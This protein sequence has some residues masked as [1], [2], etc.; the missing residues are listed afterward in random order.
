[1]ISP[2]CVM[3]LSS[4]ADTSEL[5]GATKITTNSQIM[6]TIIYTLFCFL[7]TNLKVSNCYQQLHHSDKCK[8][9]NLP[10]ATEKQAYF[11]KCPGIEYFTA[12]IENE[13]FSMNCKVNKRK[14]PHFLI[15]E[16]PNFYLN[17]FTTVSISVIEGVFFEK[18]R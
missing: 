14:W 11:Y 9:Y 3:P 17:V 6:K 8:I 13:V 1:M 7:T 2:K 4:T 12:T 15:E 5:S 18:I 10:T 16:W